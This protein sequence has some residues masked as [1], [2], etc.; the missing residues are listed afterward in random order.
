[1]IEGPEAERTVISDARQK[2]LSK[3]RARARAI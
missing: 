2:S 3:V 1:M